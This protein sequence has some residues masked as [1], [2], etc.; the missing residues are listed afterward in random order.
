MKKIG[1]VIPL[2]IFA[3]ALLIFVFVVPH[4]KVI[5]QSALPTVQPAPVGSDPAVIVASAVPATV[6][7]LSLPMPLGL[8]GDAVKGGAFFMK[9]C[10]TCHGVQGDGNGPRAYFIT[11]PPRNFLLESSRQKLNRP[12]LFEAITNGRL[13]TNM[14][15]WG[16]VLNNQEIANVAEFVFQ[17]FINAPRENQGKQ[18]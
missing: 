4:G 3:V 15:A 5:E 2:I 14:P 9:N 6:A 17:N 18:K 8:K 13:G 1:I 16:K 11:P 10:F 12:V 7:D